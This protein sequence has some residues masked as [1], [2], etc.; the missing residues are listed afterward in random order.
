[1]KSHNYHRLQYRFIAFFV[2]VALPPL[3]FLGLVALW[4]VTTTRA[5]NVAELEL[6]LAEN[7]ADR[8]EKFVGDRVQG[9]EL[10]VPDKAI[11][12]LS[13]VSESQQATII[14]QLLHLDE[15][16][17]IEE[18]AMVD[19]RGRELKKVRRDGSTTTLLSIGD[20]EAFTVARS[21]QRY[22]GSV[23]FTNGVPSMQ[24]AARILNGDGFFIGVLTATMNLSSIQDDILSRVVLGD[25]GYMYVV[26]EGGRLIGHSKE[27]QRIGDRVDAPIVASVLRGTVHTGKADADR[28]QGVSGRVVRAAA[29][30]LSS[31]HLGVVVEWPE[32]EAFAV[33]Y[34]IQKQIVIFVFST[35]VLIFL[36]ALFLARAITKP[37][38]RLRA[39]V[40]MI[41]GGKF[42]H[43]IDLH[44]HDELQELA[45]S[46]N[47]MAKSLQELD[48]LRT[49][50]IR[51][52]VLAE[53]LKKEQ[54][55]SRA[56]D[57]FISVM[58]H[59]LRTPLTSLQWSM[60]FLSGELAKPALVKY[61]D[62]IKDGAESAKQVTMIVDDLLTVAELGIGYRV[63]SPELVDCAKLIRKIGIELTARAEA[64]RLTLVLDVPDAPLI[65]E[66]SSLHLQK[67]FFN[68]LDNAITYTKEG[69]VA[70][71]AK[72][73]ADAITVTLA[74]TGIGIPKEEQHDAFKE[75]FR[76]TNAIVGK[77]VG[78]GLGLFIVK[79]VIAG[80][81]GTI[82][83]VSEEGKGT[84][85]TVVLPKKQA[86][87]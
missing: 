86:K 7:T 59:Q 12:N 48:A 79:T 78:T 76:A 69:R 67:M 50:Q 68:L 51:S 60:E 84:T 21:A 34:T 77:N 46:F 80:H 14:D 42:D 16:K 19:E 56:K 85:F 24:V 54:E 23:Y 5:V 22:F 28:Y 87:V 66:G 18:I 17:G 43:Q 52:A 71:H 81:G 72:E 37:I 65:I 9:L 33:V 38:E 73:D 70:I 74:D 36:V 55:L 25:T 40:A 41:G 13:L 82:V 47:A 4:S 83:F 27:K 75:F 53:A 58:S 2:I 49:T 6:Q 44:R 57:T 63:T 11:T 64:K 31:L 29:V 39:G 8:I 10:H 35:F 45:E 61:V 30:P 1:M 26:G 20:T 62:F 15:F 32:E 3:L